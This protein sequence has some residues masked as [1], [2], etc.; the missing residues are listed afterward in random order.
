MKLSSEAKVGS[1]VVIA[2]ALLAYIAVLLGGGTFGT[3]TYRVQAVFRQVDG[4]KE[5]CL[6][7]YAGVHV[8]KVVELRAKF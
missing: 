8:G 6:V 1:V 4:L 2:L 5:G 7:R 3:D